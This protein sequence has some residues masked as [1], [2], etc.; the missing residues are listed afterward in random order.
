MILAFVVAL[1]L[2]L[3]WYG[4]HAM[5]LKQ[6]TGLLA[7]T[8]RVASGD[9]DARVKVA[10]SSNEISQL[11][12]EF[13]QM[14][15]ALEK[16][17]SEIRHAEYLLHKSRE[18]LQ[19]VVE[20]VPDIIYTATTANNFGATFVSPALTRILGFTPE[21][22]VANPGLW[23]MSIHDEDRERVLT[24]V[25]SVIDGTDDGYS[26][27]YR[28]W[29]KDRQTLHWFED[30]ARIN[31][32]AA[33]RATSIYGVMSDINERKQ[34]EM[35]SARMGRIL[36]ESWDEIYVFNASTLRF[37]DVSSGACR[38]LGY[39][40]EELRQLTL[41]DLIPELTPEQ[42]AALIEPL[43]LGEEQ[44]VSLE[45]K[46][47]RKEGGHYPVEIR[48]QLSSAE[49]P[50]VFIAISQDISERRR[51]IAELEHK[52]LYDSLTNLPNHS[53]FQDHLDQALKVAR[54]DVSP[55]AVLTIDVRRLREVNDT[56]GHRV[57]D[58][59][60]QEIASRLQK[61]VRRVDTVARLGGDVF[62]VV[63][64]GV[65]KKRSSVT[66]GKLQKQFVQPIVIED[67]ALEVE[68]AI[69]I[70]LYPEHGDE[71][72]ILLQHA[73]I[74]MRM[75][76]GE[77]TGFSIYNSEDDT[78]DLRKLRLQGE[79]RK[80]IEQKELVL[81]YQP[82]IDLKTGRATSVE[83]LT[84]WP[85]PVQGMISP[86]DFIPMIEQSGL[87]R[88]FTLWVL[89]EAIKQLKC[90]FDAGIDLTV[91][92]NLSPRNLLDPGLLPN[93]TKLLNTHN[94]SPA[95]LILEVTESTVMSR[96]EAVLA[97][98]TQLHELAIKL[99]IDDFGTGYSSLA[100][101]KRLPLDE[102]KIDQTF[103]SG[104]ATNDEDA[105]I[106]RSTIDL[107]HNMG[108]RVV[109]EG[110]EDQEILDMLVIL[111]CDIA[112][113]YHMSRPVPAEELEQWLLSSPWGLTN[114][115]AAGFRE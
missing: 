108:L 28:M 61:G 8:R 29:H 76:K 47:R 37:F 96:P 15:A 31:R 5:V 41:L 52:A 35:L 63:L 40:V 21:E 82:K 109:A 32:D 84:R 95:R 71:P 93:I 91:A 79:L 34:A 11:G 55:L 59:V 85:H 60:L 58:L 78:Y 115:K 1:M 87:I 62:A 94:V 12:R 100:Y 112:Q 86:A 48:I 98:L 2:L 70:A 64:S 53:L 67:T 104:L 102:L 3:A 80:A 33:G 54:R 6:V 74:A 99:S 26:L 66:A 75:A 20:T 10:D 57:G 107:A 19:H 90:W 111:R 69:G 7:V 73:N 88:P 4:S 114:R 105:I 89:E 27:E 42:F 38:K 110:V 113:G 50:P 77:A 106:V 83:A 16:R 43:R 81:Y 36:E 101:L 13:N 65:S 14:I 9:L 22:F 30:R 39:S 45:T 92:V 68:A 44:Q 25:R 18:D 103:T 56:L 23:A 72:E 97:V 17:D 51:Y 24:H 49:I 46:Q